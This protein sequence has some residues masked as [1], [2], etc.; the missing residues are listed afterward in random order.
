MNV[1]RVFQRL[2]PLLVM[3]ASS[4]PAMA[5]SF[6]LSSIPNLSCKSQCPK[7]IVA[8]GE[9]EL[10]SDETFL[11]FV[12]SEV[13]P[14]QVTSVVLMS[15]PGGN[16]VGSLKLGA[17]MRQL[18]FSIMI[19]QVRNGSFKSARCYSACAYALA[20]GVKR[21]VP[22]GSEVGVHK[23]WTIER[24]MR[25]IVGSGII[26]NRVS[27]DGFTPV[28]QR[29][30]KQMGVSQNL[31]ALADATPSHDIRV[32]S[33]AELAKLRVMTAETPQRKRRNR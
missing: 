33:R 25:D 16:L 15:S 4:A 31:M 29:Y 17:M 20:G 22:D 32:L 9:I 26:G 18:G 2:L 13:L 30:L 23:A 3:A 27:V 11:S 7:I 24:P 1:T 21:I 10:N 14:R 12:K 5:M 19:G 6:S 8:S 28:L